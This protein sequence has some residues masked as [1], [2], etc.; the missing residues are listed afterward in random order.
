MIKFLGAFW[1]IP[2]TNP[3]NTS[4]SQKEKWGCPISPK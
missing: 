4:L 2:E 3:K 1:G